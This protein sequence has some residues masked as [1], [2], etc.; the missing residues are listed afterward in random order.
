M[1]RHLHGTHHRVQDLRDQLFVGEQRRARGLATYFLCRAA[2]IDVDDLCASLHVVAS[3]LCHAHRII[4][5]DL[6]RAGFYFGIVAGAPG[7]LAGLP[8]AGIAA[9]HL[10]YHQAGAQIGAQAA[11]GQVGDSRHGG[12]CHPVCQ[13]VWSDV[14]HAECV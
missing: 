3:S 4:A 2:H 9:D 12:Q 6:H 7:G 13:L 14:Q 10:R 8:Q 11:K 5:G 1:D